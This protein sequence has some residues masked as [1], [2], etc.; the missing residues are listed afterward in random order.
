MKLTLLIGII[1]ILVSG[2]AATPTAKLPERYPLYSPRL[3]SEDIR[4]IKALVAKRRDIRQ[5]ILE[6]ETE[7]GVSD[8]AT[9]TA[10]QWSRAGD[11]ADYFT[12][13]KRHGKWR[14]I[15][16][17]QHDTLKQENILV[18]S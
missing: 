2:C 14:I 6:I 15:S 9:V 18:T 10:G 11:V 4:D 17:I 7:E 5:P 16:R 1:A 12:V 13:A 8:R 3:S